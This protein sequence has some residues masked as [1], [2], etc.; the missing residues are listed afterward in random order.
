LNDLTALRT[1]WPAEPPGLPELH[2]SPA[3]RRRRVPRQCALYR[4][5][6]SVDEALYL[7]RLG[8]FKSCRA[9]PAGRLRII[10]FELA[11]DFLGLEAIGLA[12]H[13][14]AALALEDSEVYEIPSGELR[15]P[16]GALHA[17]LSDEVA[18]SQDLALMLRDC[19]AE[20][21]LAALLL[22]LSTRFGALGYSPSCFR[23]PMS[24]QDIAEFLGQTSESVSRM[25]SRFKAAGLLSVDGRLVTLL[26]PQRLRC[27]AGAGRAV[28]AFTGAAPRGLAGLARARA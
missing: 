10:G 5:G 6:D 1:I 16:A 25:L 2:W 15:R 21:R 7:V 24:R 12:R 26:A 27:V 22:N 20:Q 14:C 23:L 17:L 9:E 13:R 4:V 8:G 3:W 18:R 19:G 11:G 28:Q